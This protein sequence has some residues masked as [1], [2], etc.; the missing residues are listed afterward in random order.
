MALKEVVSFLSIRFYAG[1][2]F[3]INLYLESKN[4]K[5]SEL[6]SLL[7]LRKGKHGY[8]I[9]TDNA[10]GGYS[11]VGYSAGSGDRGKHYSEYSSG[12]ISDISLYHTGRQ[13]LPKTIDLVSA[14]IKTIEY[15]ARVKTGQE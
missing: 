9:H 11:L 7:G 14:M 8:M 12:A 3:S 2:V 10:Y 15:A 5:L 6:N 13:S 1:L 4:I